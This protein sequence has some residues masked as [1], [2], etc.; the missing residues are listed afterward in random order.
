MMIV[1]SYEISICFNSPFENTIVGWIIDNYIY[2]MARNNN[3][4]N[5]EED[6]KSR[7]DLCLSKM[8]IPFHDVLVF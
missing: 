2:V 1:S 3:D 8:K 4:K 6:R 5:I 7:V